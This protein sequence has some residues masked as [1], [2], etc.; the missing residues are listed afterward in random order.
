M[1]FD[2]EFKGQG[3]T[4][5]KTRQ[6]GIDQRSL[7]CK[8]RVYATRQVALYERYH[9]ILWYNLWKL[10]QNFVVAFCGITKLF[11]GIPQIFVAYHLDVNRK[12]P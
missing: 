5:S 8:N 4:I 11:C 2:P 1:N 10:P 12:S 3:H 7:L 9:K 6:R